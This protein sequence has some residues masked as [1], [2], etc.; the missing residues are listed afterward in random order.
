LSSA[1]KD[2]KHKQSVCSVFQ[3]VSSIT[4]LIL[5]PLPITYHTLIHAK[6]TKSCFCVFWLCLVLIGFPG[7]L[8]GFALF[9]KNKQQFTAVD[10]MC[11]RGAGSACFSGQQ[12]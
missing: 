4:E 11:A 2:G 7:V 5:A 6:L 12:G 9:L 10:T 3:P 1:F 8:F